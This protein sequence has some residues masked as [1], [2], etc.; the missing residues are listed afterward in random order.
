[1][2]KKILFMSSA[3]LSVICIVLLLAVFCTIGMSFRP[4]YSEDEKE[5]L[6]SGPRRSHWTTSGSC[7]STNYN[8]NI[9]YGKVVV[10]V[11]DGTGGKVSAEGTNTTSATTG[12]N[13]TTATITW[14]CGYSD[15]KKHTDL[16]TK[17]T[18]SITFTATPNTGYNFEGWYSDAECTKLLSSDLSYPESFKIEHDSWGTSKNSAHET[19]NTAQTWNRYAKFVEIVPIDITFIA[20]GDGGQYTVTVD[21]SSSTVSSSNVVKTGITTAITLSAT[22]ASGYIFVGWYQQDG[23]GNITDLSSNSPYEKTFA[24]DVIVGARFV[25]TSTPKFKNITT[26][27]EYYG[28]KTATMAAASGQTIVPVAEETLVDGSDLIAWTN[29]SY[30]IPTGVTLLVPYSSANTVQ[31]TPKVVTTEAALS[32]YRKLILKNSVNINCYGTICVGGQAMAGSAAPTGYVTGPCGMIDMSS[33][34]HI[35]LNSGATLYAWG[36]IKG[37]DMDQGNNTVGVGT[38]TANSGATIWEAFA[39]GDWRGGTATSTIS[40]TKFFP[41]QSYYIQNIE[42]PVTYKYSS[43]NSN[44]F[45]L[46]ATGGPYDT[47]FTLIG[48][49]NSLFKLTDSGAQVRKWYDPTTDLMCYELKGTALLDELK[50]KISALF[51]TIDVS[52]GD[53]NLPINSNMHIIL[54]DCDMTINKPLVMQ[55]GAKIEIKPDAK[56]TIAT[57]VFLYDKDD[58]GPWVKAKYFRNYGN[59]YGILTSHKNRGDGSSNELLDDA[60]L[61]IDGQLTISNSGKLYSSAGGADIMGNGGGKVIYPSSLPNSTTIPW[62][63]N[64]ETSGDGEVGTTTME[65]ANL[66][67]EDGSYT[68]SIASKTFLNING[69]WFN[70]TDGASTINADHTYN[71]TYMA[72]GNSGDNVTTP[73]LYGEDKTGLTASMKWCNVIQDGTCSAIYNAIQDLNGTA[74]AN[75]RYTYQSSDW[76]QL[77]KT[78]TEG[79]YGGSDNSLYA[80]DGCTISSLGSVD[81]NCL[82]T[83]DGVKKALVDGHFVALEKNDDDEAFHNTANTEEYYISFAGCTW[84]PATKYAGEEKAYIVEGGDYIWYNNDWLLV[85]R[86]DP[87][88]F[89]YND[90]N[91]K[92]YYEYENGEWVLAD[93]K[94]RVTDA[95]ET[96]DFYFLPDAITVASGKK[97]ATITI[98][99]DISGINS[100]MTYSASNTTCT[101]DLNGHTVSGAAPFGDDNNRGLLKINASGTTFTITDNSA[102]K[103]GRIENICNQNKVTYTVHLMAGT[104]NVEHGTIY[105]ENPAQYASKDATV[106]DVAVKKLDACGARAV[107]VGAGQKLNINGGRLEAFATRN[108]FGIVASGNNANT[109]QVTI[110]DGEIYAEAP[111]GAYAINCLGKLNVSRG[112]IEAKLNDHLVDA[113]YAADNADNNIKKHQTCYGI[114]MQGSANK[115]ATS[116]YFGTLTMTGGTVKATSDVA[117][118]YTSNVFGINL[119]A[120]FAGTGAA[121]TKATDGSLSQKYAAKATIENAKIEV[122]TNANYGYGIIG[123]GRYNSADKSTSVIKI[124]N[125]EVDVYARTQAYGIVSSVRISTGTGNGGCTN[126][127]IE[128][129]NCDVYSETTVGASAYAIWSSAT[130][131]AVYEYTYKDG[132]ATATNSI[133]AGEYAI[134]A[135]MTVHSGRYEAKSKTSGAYA[136]GTSTK[137]INTYSRHSGTALY[138]QLGGQ[139][140]DYST[141]NIEDGTFIATAGTETARAVSNGGNTTITGGTFQA[142]ATTRYAYC[143]YAISGTLNVSNAT[144]TATSNSNTANGIHL[145]GTIASYTMFAYA[146]T[147]TLTNLNVTATTGTGATARALYVAGKT[148]TQT[149]AQKEALTSSNRNNY[150]N[151]YQVG[152]KA[153]AP[154]VTVHGGTYTATAGTSSAFGALSEKTTVSTNKVETA[155]PEMTL[156][157][158]TFIAQTGTSTTAYGVQAG[159]PTLIE[160]CTITATAG[161]STKYQSTASGVRAVDKTTT[162]KNSTITATATDAAYGLEGY[163]EINATHG[164]CFHGEFDLSEAGNTEVTAEAKTSGKKA[165]TI[166]LNATKKAIASGNFAGDYATAANATINGGTYVAKFNTSGTAYVISLGAKQTQGSIV[167]QPEVEVLDGFFNGA[168]AEVGTAGVVGHMQLKGGYFV[169]PTN[170]ATYA[171]AP[172]SV[173]TLPN[174]HE[175]YNPY[176]Y[177]V[178]E[179]YTITFKNGTTQLQQNDLETG[180]TPSYSGTPTKDGNAQYIYTFDGW[181]TTDGGDK[182]AALPAVTANAIYY[183]HFAQSENKYSV[184]VEASANGSVSPASVSEIGCE[185]ASADI[186]ATPDAGYAFNGWTLPDGVTAADGYTVASNPIRIHAIAADK[187]ITANFVARTDINYT[188]KHWQQNIADDD[189]TEVTADQETLQGTTATLTAATAKTYTGFTALPITQET[190]AG[191]GTT[192]VN[193]YYNRNTYTITWVDGDGNTEETDPKVKYGAMPSYDGATPTKTATA[194]Y[195]Y[196]FNNTWSPAIVAVTGDA[197]YTA[198]FN[199]TVNKYDITWVDGNGTTLKTEKVEYGQTPAY[200]GATPTKTATAQYTYTFNNTWSPAIVAVTEAATYT[201]QFSSTPRSYTLKWNLGGGSIETAGTADGLVAYGTSLTAPVVTKTGYTFAGWHNGT[202]IVTPSTMPAANTTYTATWTINQYTLTV[203]SAD[204][205]MG[206]VTGGGTYDYNTAHTITASPKTG[207]KFVQWND[208]NENAERSVT[209]TADVT[210]TAMFDYDIANYT[211]K[212]WQQNINDDGYTEVVTDRQTNLSGTI[213]TTTTAEAKEYTGFDA[214]P[215]SQQTIEVSGTVVNIYYNRNTYTITWVDGDENTIKTD[216]KVKYGATPS[217]TGETPTKSNTETHTF[218][219]AGWVPEIAVV[220]DNAIYTAKFNAHDLDLHVTEQEQTINEDVTITTTTITTNGDLEVTEGNTLTTT[221]L[222][223]EASLVDD[224]EASGEIRG[225]GTVTPTGNVYFDLKLNTWARHW[226]AFGVPWKIANLRTTKLVEI[227]TKNGAPC[228]NE[229]VLGRDYDIVYYNGEKRA[230]QG[231]GRHCWDYV[232]DGDGTLDPGKAYLIGFIRPTGTVRFTKEADAPIRRPDETLD[233]T[234]YEGNG[235]GTDAGWNAI[236][237]PKTY[238]AAMD[239][240]VSFYHVHNGDTMRSDGFTTKQMSEVKFVVGTAVFVQAN[241]DKSVVDITRQRHNHNSS[242]PAPRRAAAREDAPKYHAV[243]IMSNNKSAD[244]IY[245]K[246][247]EDKETDSY[248]NGIDVA[249]MGISTV[250]AQIWVER[251]NTQL[252]VNTMAPVNNTVSYP[253]GISVPQAG[254]YEIQLSDESSDMIYLTYDSRIIWNLSYSPYVA[255]LEKGANTH[256]GI[257][258][259]VS[260]TPAITTDVEKAQDG[261]Q[262]AVQKIIIEDKVYILRG[263]KLYTIT[264]QLVQ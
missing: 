167:A 248:T 242:A 159:G 183:A 122:N 63:R 258:M 115:A 117:A 19:A 233:V 75:I 239:A 158:A 178:T 29:D 41:F 190:I 66:C 250:R 227:K 162:I 107:Q 21:G 132:V 195:T 189:Y 124:K 192:V 145:E 170:L 201:A 25:S 104:L 10:A 48:N 199:S 78:E 11:K 88:F 256:Y 5:L 138:Q 54:T 98:L 142:T 45:V 193:I 137:Q 205:A 264:G 206:T 216:E 93:P 103:E 106:N 28:L 13:S 226:R 219:F 39:T 231:P 95:I 196:T 116:C 102:N 62:Y 80:L 113:S 105:A 64:T 185:T 1:M 144:I 150:Y 89:D 109:T 16:E 246:A 125:T 15:S 35:E 24:S 74:A 26:G 217:Y 65:A 171:V 186:T 204:E 174:T 173:W 243:H 218:V 4:V 3:K 260:K 50:I 99:K 214:Q 254:E 129:T 197:T 143:I 215:F 212:H 55:P 263:E 245:I 191:D 179:H 240:G 181:S 194:Q 94:V 208:G 130:Q 126:A 92:R 40:G 128:L 71:F 58:W 17:H 247:D 236:A 112:L 153:I 23:A 221:D 12:N 228:H 235:V 251:Y 84:H 156:K 141:L 259:V 169:H 220:T 151:I 32:I 209:V 96:R 202:G 223:L 90:Q 38:I 53:F 187:T 77:L 182:L 211:V 262:Q 43:T 160:G 91:V 146:P 42:V 79:V 111:C 213:G 34:G 175:H 222:V 33:G 86:E 9:D 36:F 136:S 165:Y 44:Y 163:V 18:N 140:E 22:P 120:D 172:K 118:D 134:G 155:S 57:N 31:T 30:T 68:K 237:N 253:L 27:T 200:S 234:Y 14:N 110:T 49:T 100:R 241:P 46:N 252:A 207:Y 114:Y 184:S 70:Q 83:I 154:T 225:A 85:E 72:S 51:L 7:G 47:K 6:M 157:N 230:Q 168:T 161:N 81:E 152:E 76:L 59:T 249:K 180:T 2:S 198:Q 133:Y 131:G 108:A 56:V 176:K 148:L 261:T 127:D 188:V 69:R 210:Y 101:L 20:P 238:H 232:E 147:A 73:A 67:N 82:Y 97:N 257:R 203:L 164:Y 224:E 37:Q 229:L 123:Y 52:S 255:N 119:Y 139:V 121:N 135:N 244:R 166:Y 177:K 61:I 149:E 8:N 87:F 60:Q